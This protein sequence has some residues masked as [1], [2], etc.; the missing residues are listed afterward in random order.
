MRSNEL[1]TNRSEYPVPEPKSAT[2]ELNPFVVR[3]ASDNLQ[4]KVL[5]ELIYSPFQHVSFECK[6][7]L[8]FL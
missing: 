1:A 2:R 6:K 3:T 8:Q 7:D 4:T 5:Q